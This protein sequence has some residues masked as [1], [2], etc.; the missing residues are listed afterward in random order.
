MLRKFVIALALMFLP[1]VAFAQEHQHHG[2]AKKHEHHMKG[3]HKDF[4]QHLIEK[5]ADL[6]LTDAQIEKLRA[7]SAKMGEHHKAMTK[8]AKHDTKAE[9]SLHGELMAIFTEEQLEK[10]RPLMKAH[11][12]AMCGGAQKHCKVEHNPL[13][14]N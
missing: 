5:R 14:R 8:A 6:N 10:V 9:S 3:E 1:T 7:L 4:A 11:M 13:K 2:A 12:D